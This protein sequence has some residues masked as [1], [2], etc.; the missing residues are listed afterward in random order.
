MAAESAASTE[1]A[2]SLGDAAD[3]CHKEAA[4]D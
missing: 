1:V 4:H 3:R 2:V